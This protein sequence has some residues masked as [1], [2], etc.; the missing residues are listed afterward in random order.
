MVNAQGT[1]NGDTATGSSPGKADGEIDASV[2]LIQDEQIPSG[3]VHAVP[4]MNDAP[5]LVMKQSKPPMLHL[6]TQIRSLTFPIV[7]GC[8]KVPKPGGA[9]QGP[10]RE[11]VSKQASAGMRRTR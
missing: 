11:R 2:D 7:A 1:V 9:S 4:T 8:S 3:E 10:K 6:A 5:A